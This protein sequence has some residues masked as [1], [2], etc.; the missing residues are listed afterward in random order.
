[1][2]DVDAVIVTPICEY[3]DIRKSISKKIVA[4]IISVADIVSV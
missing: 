1:M 4:E 3:E 2:P